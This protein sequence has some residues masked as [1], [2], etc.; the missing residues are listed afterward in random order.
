VITGVVKAG[1]A[2]MLSDEDLAKMVQKEVAA[3]DNQNKVCGENNKYTKRLRSLTKG[4]KDANG[5]KLNFKVYQTADL[6]AFAC[7]DGSVRVFVM[8]KFSQNY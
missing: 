8:A 6:N 1:K 5:I 7:P 2:Y 4:M 3:M